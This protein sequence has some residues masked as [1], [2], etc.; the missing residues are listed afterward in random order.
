ML[1][2]TKMPKRQEITPFEH[3]R[4]RCQTTKCKR[5]LTRLGEPWNCWICLHCNSH[6]AEVTKRQKA[7]K[8][9]QNSHKYIKTGMTPTEV[10]DLI[11]KRVSEALANLTAASKGKYE[12]EV[13]DEPDDE[14]AEPPEVLGKQLDDFPDIEEDK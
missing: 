2:E 10:D 11:E 14:I 7:H 9:D 6:P 8:L 12:T 13:Q 4:I 3:K 5:P 1:T